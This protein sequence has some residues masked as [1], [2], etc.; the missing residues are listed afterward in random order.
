MAVKVLEMVTKHKAGLQSTIMEQLKEL[1]QVRTRLRMWV[2]LRVWCGGVWCGGV[3]C[4]VVWCIQ[5]AAA[6]TQAARAIEPHPAAA[7]E[8]RS[9]GGRQSNLCFC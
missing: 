3:C 4:G 9:E 1:Q 2:R 5:G 6:G 7:S 8:A